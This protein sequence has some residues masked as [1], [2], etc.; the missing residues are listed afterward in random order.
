MKYNLPW[1]FWSCSLL[2]QADIPIIS[3]AQVSIQ[4]F[5]S[6]ELL[7]NTVLYSKNNH[8][9]ILKNCN[10]ITTLP[11]YLTLGVPSFKISGYSSRDA[12]PAIEVHFENGVSDSMVLEPYASSACNFIGRL[13]NRDSNVA[14]T[15]CL[16]KP[17]DKMDI[18]LLSDLNTN[19]M[20]QMDFF[21]NVEVVENPFKDQGT[22]PLLNI[23]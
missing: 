23:S 1:N 4:N 22:T 7:K 18:T 16:N 20:F 14:V 3:P 19:H 9:Y 21:G 13:A 5:W 17:G 11:T 10:H 8:I 15:G 12:I 2:L 6:F